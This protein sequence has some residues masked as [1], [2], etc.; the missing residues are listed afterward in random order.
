MSD[1]QSSCAPDGQAYRC[2]CGSTKP[3]LFIS[4][5]V[6]F[7]D[8]DDAGVDA[9]GERYKALKEDFIH[10]SAD[11]YVNWEICP[12]CLRPIGDPSLEH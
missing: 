8:A 2:P 7:W 4:A 1:T 3:A 9:L 11:V 10:L 12:D 5:R 6:D